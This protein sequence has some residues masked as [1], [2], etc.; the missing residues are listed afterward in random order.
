MAESPYADPE[1]RAQVVA[2]IKRG[3]KGGK[4]DQWSARKSQ[5]ATAEYEKR[6][7][8]KYGDKSP[9]TGP[10][11][12]EQRKLVKWTDE[13]WTTRDGKNAIRKDSKGNVIVKRYL[14]AEAWRNLSPAEARATDKKKVKGKG[15]FVPNTRKA[16][17]AA[18]KARAYHLLLNPNIVRKRN[19]DYSDKTMWATVGYP[20]DYED[21]TK[22]VVDAGIE[23][24]DDISEQ[25]EA[26]VKW[27]D[28]GAERNIYAASTNRP[29]QMKDLVL[30]IN[31]NMQSLG[32]DENS[33]GETGYYEDTL[34]RIF[35]EAGLEDLI[36]PAMP[37]GPHAV[38]QEKADL[39]EPEGT[40]AF[41]EWTGDEDLEEDD[42]NYFSQNNNDLRITRLAIR[43][44]K[45]QVLERMIE[46]GFPQAEAE[47]WLRSQDLHKGN[48]AFGK[49]TSVAQEITSSGNMTD[50]VAKAFG[51]DTFGIE[52]V[53]VPN[54]RLLDYNTGDLVNYIREEDGYGIKKK[55]V[56]A[57]KPITTGFWAQYRDESYPGLQP[58][59]AYNK[60]LFAADL[61]QQNG[62]VV[63][64]IYKKQKAE[65][66]SS[67][68][69]IVRNLPGE[70]LRGRYGI[71]AD[72]IIQYRPAT[73]S[74]F[75]P[76]QVGS[77]LD[78]GEA[79]S[80]W[81][82]RRIDGKV[83]AYAASDTDQE[84]AKAIAKTLRDAGWYARVVPY[85][86]PPGKPRK[87]KIKRNVLLT[88]SIRFPSPNN[89]RWRVFIHPKKELSNQM[90]LRPTRF[91]S[92]ENYDQMFNSLAPVRRTNIVAR[93]VAK[94]A[95]A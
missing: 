19:I 2:E 39:L 61:F 81:P 15:Q 41:L 38:L 17:K 1:L 72:S 74:P 44:W 42:Q 12:Q 80:W 47:N 65:P 60:S 53:V 63:E 86:R 90:G 51:V 56:S 28:R 31:R 35:T 48:F 34:T 22:T 67:N 89:L 4:K 36:V 66:N 78:H 25:L 21:T 27:I 69:E 46:A 49:G 50:P 85:G 40:F 68:L 55:D 82:R 64:A 14:P 6:F 26:D 84:S 24:A 8:E 7:A 75:L 62:R 23:L 95:T 11:T 93:P 59:R 20:E 54:L 58:V 9:Y 43:E 3:T 87:G 18:K 76:E 83:W 5:F 57:M 94:K 16:A 79:N 73:L 70:L 10:R 33:P 91:F 45:R 77:F 37:A 13:N 29:G 52:E 32:H 71:K 88:P 92:K 30:K